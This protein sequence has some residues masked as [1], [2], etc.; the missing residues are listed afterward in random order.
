MPNRIRLTE[1]LKG[2]PQ[3]DSVDL[4]KSRD[5][6]RKLRDSSAARSG[7]DLAPPFA[8]KRVSTSRGSEED[9]PRV[10]RLQAALD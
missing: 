6:L 7:Y 5:M 4:K 1:I 3:I 10:V 8:G 2:N 9:D